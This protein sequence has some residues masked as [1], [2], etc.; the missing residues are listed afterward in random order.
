MTVLSCPLIDLIDPVFYSCCFTVGCCDD[1]QKMQP[2]QTL[3]RLNEF[4]DWEVFRQQLDDFYNTEPKPVQPTGKWLHSVNPRRIGLEKN[5]IYQKK[6]A[7]HRSKTD[8]HFQ[9]LKSQQKEL[10]SATISVD[11][12][13]LGL[14][15]SI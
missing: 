6:E 15:I 12:G 13:A 3:V 1:L 10:K 5:K 14:G 4:V 8:F 9:I 7:N 2:A 11:S